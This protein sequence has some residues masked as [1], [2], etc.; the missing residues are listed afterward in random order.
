MRLVG[1]MVISKFASYLT[2]TKM[3]KEYRIFNNDGASVS[4][5]DI[6]A[7]IVSVI[8]P[9]RDGNMADVVLGY[10]NLRDYFYDGPCA[11]KTP[12]R[13]ANRIA[14]G[15]FSIDGR[16]YD[17]ECN[18]GP[19]ALHG[20]PCGFHNRIWDA[21]EI[22]GGVIFRYTSADGEEGYPGRLDVEVGYVWQDGNVLTIDYKA[23]TDAPTIVNLTNHAYFNLSGHS[24]G[25]CLDHLLRLDC[26]MR[27]PSDDTDIPLGIVAPVIG[28]PMDFTVFKSL[29]RD[30]GRGFENLST[31]RGYNHFFLIDGWVGDGSLRHAATL[32]DMK[33]GRCLDVL[34][35][36]SGL[37]L[38]TG[39]WLDGSPL[40]K[41][42]R[43]YRDYDG[44]ALECQAAPDSPNH[45]GFPSVILRPGEVYRHRI[46]YRFSAE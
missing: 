9:D 1:S 24:S 25:S 2:V 14:L 26:G 18:N 41:D 13:F 7:G 42:G 15:R 45:P 30:I 12:G 5:T 34:T 33:S 23:V 11:G 17:L 37:M 8:V 32:K 3:C 43:P 31:G 21:E 36:Q 6:G 38:Y 46:V 35:T 40:N 27:L 16:V 10:R 20:G 39:N 44:V 4:L 29:G 28:T 22:P 19:N